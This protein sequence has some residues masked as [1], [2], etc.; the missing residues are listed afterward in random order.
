MV[1][2]FKNAD[3]GS[4]LGGVDYD[5]P[6]ISGIKDMIN[7]AVA[8]QDRLRALHQEQNEKEGKKKKKKARTSLICYC[9][10]PQCGIGPMM[11]VATQGE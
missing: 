4:I 9:G 2:E 11:E 1:Q 6:S 10:A 5:I 3:I 7:T 8:S